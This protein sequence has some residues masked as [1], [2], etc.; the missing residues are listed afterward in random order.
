MLPALTRYVTIKAY[1]ASSVYV[2]RPPPLPHTTGGVA[3]HVCGCPCHRISVARCLTASLS[4]AKQY[5]LPSPHCSR[6]G[7]GASA[8]SRAGGLLHQAR[9]PSTPRTHRGARAVCVPGSFAPSSLITHNAVSVPTRETAASHTNESCRTRTYVIPLI[10][11][12]VKAVR[13]RAH[14]AATRSCPKVITSTPGG[15]A[16][17]RTNL[18]PHPSTT[19]CPGQSH[20]H[21]KGPP[22]EAPT[23]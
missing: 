14:R 22:E 19:A 1:Q 15:A 23:C 12:Y 21:W 2:L 6:L 17:E 13:T 10:C 11:V 7:T 8:G 4:R 20:T 5:K 16:T 18:G 9:H 3:T